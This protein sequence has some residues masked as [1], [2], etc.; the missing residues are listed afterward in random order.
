M[1]TNLSAAQEYPLQLATSN[2]ASTPA[3]GSSCGGLAPH[4]SS[5][6][7]KKA[8]AEQRT[9]VFIDQAGFYLLPMAV[10]TNAPVRQTPILRE[11]L[12]RDHRSL[13]GGNPLS[14]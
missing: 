7:Q 4:P 5:R 8:Q 3:Q 10:R 2:P 9:L 6:T 11:T 13:I 1:N 14:L 12:T